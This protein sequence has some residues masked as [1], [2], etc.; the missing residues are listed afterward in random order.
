LYGLT[1]TPKRKHNDEDLIY[2]YIGEIIADMSDFVDKSLPP[3]KRFTT[4]IRDTK[5]SV[6]F[7]WKTDQFDLIAKII[8]CDTTRN[9][10]IIKDILEQVTLS[11]RI[12]VLSERKEHL[13]V[14]ELYLKGQCEVLIFTGDDSASGRVSKLKQIQDGHYQVLLAT[15]QIFGEGMHVENIEVLVLA[16]P[17]AFEGKL[18]QYIGRLLHS[19]SPKLLIDYH[20]KEIPFLDRQFKQR[21]RVYNKL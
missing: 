21:K 10:L 9:S 14:L 3:A 18:T 15:G 19:S 17:F 13:K 11:R 7:N 5:L 20:D 4:I 1:A 6:P 12:L 2:I 8:S 16:F